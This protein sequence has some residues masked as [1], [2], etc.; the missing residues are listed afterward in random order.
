MDAQIRHV[1][2][3]AN[4]WL[5]NAEVFPAAAAQRVPADYLVRRVSG[6]DGWP[7]PHKAHLVIG[8]RQVGKSTLLWKWIIE[9]GRPPLYLNAEEPLIRAWTRSPTM[10]LAEIA[11]LVSPSSPVLIDEAQ[12]LDEAGLLIKGLIDGGLANPLF[13]TGSSA[14]HLEART[15]ESLAGRAE[16]IRLHPLSLVEIAGDRPNESGLLRHYR[17]AELARRLMVTGGYPRVWLG[18]DAAA[19]LADL[20]TA[21]V[22]RDASDRF[23][24]ANLDA[25]RRLLLLVAGQTGS[26]VNVEEWSALCAVPRREI[27]H[28]LEIL[29][30][31]HLVARIHPFHGGRRAELVQRPKI[32][33]CDG[34][35]RNALLG[36]LT[37]FAE[38]EDSGALFE[39]WVGAELLKHLSPLLP[40]DVLRFWR[41]KAGAEVDFVL[42]RSSG[43]LGIECKASSMRAPRL[44]RSSRSFIEAYQPTEFW[45]VN[46]ELQ[47][48]ERHGATFVR[49][50]TPDW[51]ASLPF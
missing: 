20:V 48:A 17:L 42:E 30:G 15:R 10:L 7:V 9:H 11:Q 37:P 27:E 38:R 35:I 50:V 41:S 47:A 5:E 25:F 12:H 4:P 14:F 28:Y 45:V 24:V 34:G 6:Q 18:N 13:V 40:L 8:A 49:W 44:T 16:R 39:A 21:F 26:L 19:T 46:L 33:F 2:L 36:R 43:L 23:A 51:F 3:T 1:L 22:L 29:E 32:Y 31:S